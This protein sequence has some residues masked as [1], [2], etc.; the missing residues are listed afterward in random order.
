MNAIGQLLAGPAG[1][2]ELVGPLRGERLL[3]FDHLGS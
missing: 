1:E 3:G 2:V